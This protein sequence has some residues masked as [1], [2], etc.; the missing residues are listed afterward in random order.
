MLR[1]AMEPFRFMGES[2]SHLAGFIFFFL[3]LGN[4]ELNPPQF[5][6]LSQGL[7]HISIYFKSLLIRFYLTYFITYSQLVCMGQIVLLN[8]NNSV[9]PNRLSYILHIPLILLTVHDLSL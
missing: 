8:F 5:L 7:G 4:V 3:T 1:A 9:H 2:D 6:P